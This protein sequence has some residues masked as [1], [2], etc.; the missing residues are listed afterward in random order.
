MASKGEA[1]N[2]QNEKK[3]DAEKKYYILSQR[4][5]LL[6]ESVASHYVNT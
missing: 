4:C 5:K 3:S 6:D 2:A 1:A